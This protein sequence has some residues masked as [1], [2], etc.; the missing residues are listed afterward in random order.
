MTQ[1]NNVHE[2]DRLEV[3]GE[4]RE[5]ISGGLWASLGCLNSWL[6]QYVEIA[7]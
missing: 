3:I 6:G 1:A 7:C 4:V 5:I 2:P